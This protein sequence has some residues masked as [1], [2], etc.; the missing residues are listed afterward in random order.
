MIAGLGPGAPPKGRVQG[1]GP[2]Q[3][4][5]PKR[6]SQRPLRPQ[7]LKPEL[8]IFHGK[9]QKTAPMQQMSPKRSL[10]DPWGNQALKPKLF[11]FF[12]KCR[13]TGPMQPMT[14]RRPSQDQACQRGS[15]TQALK[16]DI[17]N[18]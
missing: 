13:K 14:Q 11:I 9:M 18:D 8:F 16:K 4:M 3:P 12:G 6:S 2:M 15:P 1:G 17:F 5:S 10:R 7:A